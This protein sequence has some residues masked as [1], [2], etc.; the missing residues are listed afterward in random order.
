MADVVSGKVFKYIFLL[1]Q[2]AIAVGD[3]ADGMRREPYVT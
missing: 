2:Y 1:R 3:K